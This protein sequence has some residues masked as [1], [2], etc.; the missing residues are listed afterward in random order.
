MSVRLATTMPTLPY[1]SRMA[2][3]FTDSHDRLPSGCCTPISTSR[4]ATP[5]DRVMCTGW[6]RWS[7]GEP[8]SWMA[9]HRLLPAGLAASMRSAAALLSRMWPWLSCT[10][11]P[12]VTAPN[13]DAMRW[14]EF[15]SAIDAWR[16]SVMSVIIAR[17][18]PGSPLS[19][20][21]LVLDSKPHRLDWSLRKKRK[22]TW[23]GWLA[24]LPWLARRRCISS[25]LS[26]SM[27][28]SRGRPSISCTV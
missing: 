27:K 17:V 9:C 19:D 14:L 23:S 20:W 21:M 6:L 10:T 1:S 4:M 18:P 13:T 22:S 15:D 24:K 8:S 16:R 26:R 25:W 11:R 3:V 7:K 12:F 28:S 2:S 5:V